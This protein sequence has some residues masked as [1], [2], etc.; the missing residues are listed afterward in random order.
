MRANSVIHYR[1]AK[2]KIGLRNGFDKHFFADGLKDIWMAFDAFLGWR[3]PAGSN[4][5]MRKKFS[6]EY[7]DI[8]EQWKMSDRFRKSLKILCDLSPV[9]DTS[10]KNPRDPIWIENPSNLF[11]VLELCYRIRSNLFH[12]GKDLETKEKHGKRNRQLVEH[13]FKVTFEI[14]EKTLLNEKIIES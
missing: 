7:Q 8:F 3:F 4:R 2:E 5:E 12:G 9:I 14:L 6:E 11:E 10:P 1:K 13:S